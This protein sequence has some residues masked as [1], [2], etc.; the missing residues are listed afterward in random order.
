MASIGWTL[1]PKVTFPMGG[2]FSITGGVY[3]SRPAA[4]A[5]A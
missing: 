1:V 3:G 4:T 2:N 5:S